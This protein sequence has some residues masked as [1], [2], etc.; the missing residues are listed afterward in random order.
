MR[1][2]IMGEKD[3]MTTMHDVLDAQW[4]LD[5]LSDEAYLRRVI[6]PLEVGQSSHPVPLHYK[7]LTLAHSCHRCFCIAFCAATCLEPTP[8]P[9]ADAA[10]QLQAGCGEGQRGECAVLRCQAD[11]SGTATLRKWCVVLRYENG[12]IRANTCKIASPSAGSVCRHR[13]GRGSG[14]DDHQGRGDCRGYCAGAF[15]KCQEARL[16]GCAVP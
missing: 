5:N 16:P 6:M 7:Q 15:A 13:A 4:A 10:H 12:P 11:D 14:A 1:S 8:A 3:N 2:G 9:S